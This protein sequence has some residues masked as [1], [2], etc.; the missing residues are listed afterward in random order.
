MIQLY[1]RRAY[2]IEKN[3]ENTDIPDAPSDWGYPQMAERTIGVKQRQ[4]STW[5]SFLQI[6]PS[7]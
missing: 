1:L 7:S 6:F 2:L 4:E 5:P 3:T